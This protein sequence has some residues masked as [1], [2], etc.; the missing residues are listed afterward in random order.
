[1][2]K[3]LFLIALAVGFS[4]AFAQKLDKVEAKQLKAFIT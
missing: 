1:M 2:K 4:S 3:V